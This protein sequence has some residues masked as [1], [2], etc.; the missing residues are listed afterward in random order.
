M[1]PSP[2]APQCPPSFRKSVSPVFSESSVMWKERLCNNPSFRGLV[3][4]RILVMDDCSGST[5]VQW[6]AIQMLRAHRYNVGTYVPCG[7]ELLKPDKQMNRELFK[8]FGGNKTAVLEFCHRP[9][10][11][12]QLD[13]R[14][15]GESRAA[16]GRGCDI[17]G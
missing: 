15:Q 10:G 14:D 12:A 6:L 5:V 17:S 11:D 2:P 13:A 8:R 3:A 1:Q 9:C 4:P 7:F 16:A